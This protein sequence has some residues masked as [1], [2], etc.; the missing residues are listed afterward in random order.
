[1][2][3]FS[4]ENLIYGHHN[5]F[6][7]DVNFTQNLTLSRTF[8]QDQTGTVVNPK[9]LWRD[10]ALKKSVVFPSKIK[11]N[12]KRD[13]LCCDVMNMFDSKGDSKFYGRVRPFVPARKEVLK[14][15]IC[16]RN[17]QHAFPLLDRSM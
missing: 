3:L 5:F 17:T 9:K 15:V 6:S 1:M 14:G 7:S 12:N 10:H 11:E 13:S 16:K 2:S 4:G 8:L